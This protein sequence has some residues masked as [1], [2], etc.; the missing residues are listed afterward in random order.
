MVFTSEVIRLEFP[1]ETVV[2]DI[3]EQIEFRFGKNM[4]DV[5]NVHG[6]LVDREYLKKTMKKTGLDPVADM[7]LYD[8]P[9]QQKDAEEEPSV[10]D[11]L[12]KILKDGIES[13]TQR[14]REILDSRNK[15]KDK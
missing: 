5:V 4:N 8:E 1:N 9:L 15:D 3:I 7:A 2:D 6:D 10:D 11:I 14:E 12:D 13:L